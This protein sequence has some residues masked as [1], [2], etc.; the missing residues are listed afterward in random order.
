[1]SLLRHARGASL[2]S[3]RAQQPSSSSVATLSRIAAIH[4]S[5]SVSTNDVAVQRSSLSDLLAG[6][7]QARGSA[8]TYE[9]S[10]TYFD[11]F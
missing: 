10:A 8:G 5:T 7:A 3:L 4:S 2:K 6:N 1:M 9:P 11:F